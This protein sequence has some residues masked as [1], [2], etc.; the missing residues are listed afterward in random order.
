MDIA[1]K[2]HKLVYLLDRKAEE[3]LQSKIKITYSQFLILLA[4]SNAL[5]NNQQCISKAL[6]I[7]PSAVSRH[8]D[9]LVSLELV[10]RVES[11]TN[12]RTNEIILTNKGKKVYEK[13]YKILD[14]QMQELLKAFNNKQK[15]NFQ[16]YLDLITISLESNK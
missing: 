16:E 5:G 13:S 14:K 4:L 8:I 12:R 7:T 11:D 6:C 1:H 15:L 9:N 10:K 3:L 2:I